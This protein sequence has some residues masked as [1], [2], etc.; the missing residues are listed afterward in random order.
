MSKAKDLINLYEM[1]NLR[2]VSTGLSVFI[3]LDDMGS[4]RRNKH[5][6]PRLK[7]AQQKANNFIGTVSISDKPIVINGYIDIDILSDISKW[8][9]LNLDVLLKHW[10]G[11]IETIELKLYLKKV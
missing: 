7:V 8:I 11:E 3:W 5:Q 1:S 6:L 4:D 2:P 9:K 10:N